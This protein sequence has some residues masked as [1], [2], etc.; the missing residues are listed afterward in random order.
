MILLLAKER[1]LAMQSAIQQC[2]SQ[3]CIEEWNSEYITSITNQGAKK[4]SLGPH[5]EIEIVLNG[6]INAKN[7]SVKRNAILV[8]RR[9]SPA[10]RVI[11]ELSA[12]RYGLI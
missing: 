9:L 3:S 7:V 4:K 5:I 10:A 1:T 2:P 11:P 12:L 6:R 8:N